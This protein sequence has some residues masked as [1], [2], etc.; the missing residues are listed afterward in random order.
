MSQIG[1]NAV[2]RSTHKKRRTQEV[3]R[4]EKKEGESN[5][6]SA[7]Q[8]PRQNRKKKLTNLKRERERKGREWTGKKG[9][10]GRG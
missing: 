1:V 3:V 6:L 4:E 5:R 2:E 7:A 8:T 10:R 9:G